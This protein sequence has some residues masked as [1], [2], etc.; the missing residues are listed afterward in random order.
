MAR[1]GDYWSEKQT[2]N[3]VNLLKEYQHVFACDYNDLKGLVEK[4]GET[5]IELIPG[6]KPIKKWSYK[7]AHKYK[8]IVQKEIEGMLQEDI[9]YPIDKVEWA[10]P[11]VV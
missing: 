3:I 2:N 11:M 6:A 1:V 5:N 10:S 9:I 7:L 4:M 8:L